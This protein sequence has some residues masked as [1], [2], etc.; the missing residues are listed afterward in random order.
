MEALKERLTALEARVDQLEQRHDGRLAGHDSE[1]A[2]LRRSFA[3]VSNDVN[4]IFS[5]LTSQAMV[6][7]RVDKGMQLILD[8]VKKS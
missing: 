6:M 5:I 1:L 3:Q 2:D 7:E 4:R 8:H